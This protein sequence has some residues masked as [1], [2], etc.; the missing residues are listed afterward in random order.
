MFKTR[1]VTREAILVSD[2]EEL[3]MDKCLSC[4]N[5]LHPKCAVSVI[6]LFCKR[7]LYF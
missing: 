3:L 2:D 1:I 4:V 5:T 6:G 7:D